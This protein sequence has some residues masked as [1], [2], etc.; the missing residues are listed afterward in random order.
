MS[1]ENKKDDLKAKEES[2]TKEETKTTSKKDS[3]KS[4]KETDTLKDKFGG[5]KAEFKRIIWPTREA[6]IKSV[7]TVIVVS[8]MFGV[9]IFG[10]DVVFQTGYTKLYGV[11]NPQAQTEQTDTDTDTDTATDAEPEEKP[12][13]E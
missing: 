1:E 5:V 10:M 13:T 8:L 7:I 6:L 11:F 2:K 9:I 4:S 3:K 12:A